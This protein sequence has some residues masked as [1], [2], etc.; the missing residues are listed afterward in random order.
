MREEEIKDSQKALEQAISKKEST[1]LLI[2]EIQK[3]LIC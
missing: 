3:K 1:V 2:P